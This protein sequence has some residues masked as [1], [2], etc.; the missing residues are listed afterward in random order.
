MSEFKQNNSD[1]VESKSA[2]EKREQQKALQNIIAS[3]YDNKS[4]DEVQVSTVDL[5]KLSKRNNILSMYNKNGELIL[6]FICGENDYP[7]SILDVLTYDS[8]VDTNSEYFCDI[9]KYAIIDGSVEF[10]EEDESGHDAAILNTVY[11]LPEVD[12]LSKWAGADAD[13]A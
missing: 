3:G 13:A 4:K 8:G 7:I 6:D 2:I 9:P 10:R 12:E 11:K 1:Q 5:K